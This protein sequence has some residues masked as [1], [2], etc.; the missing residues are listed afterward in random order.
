M[1]P[2]SST[3]NSH[4]AHILLVEAEPSLADLASFRLELLGYRL[5]LVKSCN[6]ATQA[7]REDQP[8]LIIV[9]TSL[10][11]GEGNAAITEDGIEW[12]ARLRAEIDAQEVPVLAF[13]LDPTL[14]T[15]ER[16]IR[17]GVQDY[18]ITPF[19]PTVLEDKIQSLLVPSSRQLQLNA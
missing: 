13:S 2:S 6:S 14:E 8:D 15:V 4:L 16:A 7:V 11:V 5:T 12:V 9:N 18:L 10:L 19:D 1:K 17:A 3:S